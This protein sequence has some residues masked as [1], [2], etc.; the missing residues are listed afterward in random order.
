MNTFHRRIITTAM[1]THADLQ[2]LGSVVS[3]RAS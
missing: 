1:H 3:T 2:L